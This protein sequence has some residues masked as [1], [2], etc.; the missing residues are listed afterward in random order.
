MQTVASRIK[1]YINVNKHI[2]K[3]CNANVYLIILC[4]VHD[5]HMSDGTKLGVQKHCRIKLCI[6]NQTIE[7]HATNV[8]KACRIKVFLSCAHFFLGVSYVFI[9]FPMF[10]LV[11]V[12]FSFAFDSGD[13]VFLLVSRFSSP[14]RPY[15]PTL[16]QDFYCILGNR[17][18]T[19]MHRQ[20]CDLFLKSIG[21]KNR[22]VPLA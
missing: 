8:E 11:V 16:W 13:L 7:K 22:K 4:S 21:D 6:P 1:P 19:N 3:P 20:Y 15:G 2:R 12:W 9:S 10:F 17:S 5:L 18:Y 14:W